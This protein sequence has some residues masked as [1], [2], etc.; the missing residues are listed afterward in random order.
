MKF[1]VE[2]PLKAPEFGR[3][4]LQLWDKDIVKWND[5]IGE[6]QIDLYKWLQKAYRRDET[7]LPFKE[8][9]ARR[10]RL[11]AESDNDEGDDEEDDEEQEEDSESKQLRRGQ[12]PEEE[13]DEELDGT[14]QIRTEEVKPLLSKRLTATLR[15]PTF[16]RR[17][18]H[19]K[20]DGGGKKIK[21]R[22]QDE[23]KEAIAS[24]MDFI[25]MGKLHEDADWVTIYHTDREQGA[26][27]SMGKLAV[28]IQIVPEKEAQGMPVGT[29]RDDPNVNPY[30]PPPVGRMKM[31]ANPFM[32]IKELV[33]PKT[34]V[35][36]CCLF[37]CVFCMGFVALFGAGIM[38]TLT[39][40]KQTSAAAGH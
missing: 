7:V 19:K 36:L 38:S 29:G 16:R 5:V 17:K 13:Q 15:R 30:L 11:M 32:M 27:K 28:S 37:C 18:Q 24:F 1:S 3:L 12:Q 4:H 35:K 21:N 6:T 26:S 9:N 22:D 33:G 40:L 34:C 39:Y 25:G 23:A 31:S 20:A 10:R 14:R 8:I 2:L